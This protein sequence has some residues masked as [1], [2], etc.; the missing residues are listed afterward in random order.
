VVWLYGA[1]VLYIAL[2]VVLTLLSLRPYR[3]PKWISPGGLGHPQEEIQFVSGDGTKITGWWSETPGSNKIAVLLHGYMMNRSELV[4]EAH[5]LIQRGFSCLL[6]D[7]RAHGSSH[8]APSSIGFRERQDVIAAVGYAKARQPDSRVLLVGSSMGSAAAVFAMAE[9]PGLVDAVV[10]DS[11][12]GKLSEAIHG[13]WRFLGGRGLSTFLYPLVF[14][15]GPLNRINPFKVDVSTSLARI[16]PVPVLFFHGSRDTL[17]HPAGARR[18][19]E[20]AS[21]PKRIVW[22]EGCGHSEGRWLQP[23]LYHSELAEWLS[24]QGM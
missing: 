12:Y 19:Y 21:G 24:A 14:L 13:W 6:I 22:F 4:P 5:Q 11:A 18:N 8:S 20:A 3:I 23:E 2:L 16:G 17:A 1:I 10:I 15:A 9:V 7:F